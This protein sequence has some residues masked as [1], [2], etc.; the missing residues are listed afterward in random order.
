MGEPASHT[1]LPPRRRAQVHL[2]ATDYKST[3]RVRM[4]VCHNG[5]LPFYSGVGRPETL[6]CRHVTPAVYEA[7]V[8]LWRHWWH[9]LPACA[10]GEPP[11]MF[12]VQPFDMERGDFINYH[13]DGQS[14]YEDQT[15]SMRIG[16]PV[17]TLNLFAD[18][19]F[20][21]HPMKK[22]HAQRSVRLCDG[23][24]YLWPWSDDQANKHG[25]WPPP[26]VRGGMRVSVVF[27]WSSLLARFDPSPPHRILLTLAERACIE[28]KR[29]EN[30][31]RNEEKRARW[32]RKKLPR[33][34]KMEMRTGT[35]RAV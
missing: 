16:A 11:D 24:T 22:R 26:C 29:A 27:R 20:W 33:T 14:S 35:R 34:S 21:H 28:C 13:S 15:I 19:D 17:Y 12:A 10:Q 31:A 9:D 8:A 5:R 32:K 25:A 6:T 18:F 2:N 7:G 3:R 23:M 1:A 30:A 4:G